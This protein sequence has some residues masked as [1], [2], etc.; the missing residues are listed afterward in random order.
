MNKEFI[1][2][3]IKAKK[4]EYEAIKEILPKGI[5]VRMDNLEKDAVKVL[6]DVAI[7]LIKDTEQESK[8]EV[9]KSAK[10]IKVDF[11]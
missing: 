10:K 2:K 5:K 3:I 7:E 9:V 8:A 6:K 11:S 4:L 1:V